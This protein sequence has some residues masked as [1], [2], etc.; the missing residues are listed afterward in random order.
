MTMNN[1][2]KCERCKREYDE[3][4]LRKNCLHPAVNRIYGNRIC[5]YCCKKCK[6]SKWEGTGLV[7]RYEE[8]EKNERNII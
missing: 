4:S 7:C 6:H 5:I 8:D 1:Y 3:I 2:I